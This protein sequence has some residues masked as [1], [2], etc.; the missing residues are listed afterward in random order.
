MARGSRL[1]PAVQLSAGVLNDDVTANVAKTARNGRQLNNNSKRIN[2][3]KILFF[4]DFFVVNY[5][6]DYEMVGCSTT[7]MKCIT[8]NYEIY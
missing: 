7:N 5:S 4:I 8:H 6:V 2:L 3:G 1:H